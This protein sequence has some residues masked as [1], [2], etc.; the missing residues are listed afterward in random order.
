MATDP[1]RRNPGSWPGDRPI[2]WRGVA[3]SLTWF[4]LGSAAAVVQVVSAVPLLLVAGS[5]AGESL[6]AIGRVALALAWGTLTL[7]AAWSWV[8]GRWRVV[9]APVVTGALLW[10][11]TTVAG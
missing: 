10:V 11:V 4:V 6:G 8:L 9:V 7:W 1:N 3:G 5:P 2:R